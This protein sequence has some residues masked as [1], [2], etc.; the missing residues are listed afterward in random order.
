V[1]KNMEIPYLLD[2]YGQML[3]D[4]Q[5]DVLD[6][7]YNEDLSLAEIGQNTGITRQGVRDSI[8][9]GEY[10]LFEL[11]QK[12][13]LWARVCEM[14]EGFERI[15]DLTQRIQSENTGYL[16]STAVDRCTASILEEVKKQL[17]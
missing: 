7:Y 2:F 5:R 15:R 4:K 1:A 6:L 8:K 14:Q 11:E 9:R 13:G 16:R 10:T 3:T 17:D 12:L